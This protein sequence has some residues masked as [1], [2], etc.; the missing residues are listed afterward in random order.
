MNGCPCGSGRPY[1]ECC[2]PRLDG[3][4]PAETAEQLMRSRYTAYTRGDVVY[5]LASWHP[6]TRPAALNLSGEG[7]PEWLG[8]EILTCDGGG[9]GAAEATVEFTARYR[10]GASPH[11]LHERSRFLRE[12]GRWFYLDGAVD[13]RPST[14]PGRN[15]RCPC[16]SGRKYKRCCGAATGPRSGAQ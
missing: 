4:R 10:L 12:Q 13:E 3:S 1:A 8:L 11:A 2:G 5:L 6:R 9:P 15:A 16:G 7:A 14:A